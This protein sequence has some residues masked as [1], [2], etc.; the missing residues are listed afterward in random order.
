M[1]LLVTKA[2]NWH[3]AFLAISSIAIC[4]L[5]HDWHLRF[6]FNDRT[7][8]TVY[9]LGSEMVLTVQLAYCPELQCYLTIRHSTCV[10]FSIPIHWNRNLFP[11]IST[12]LGHLILYQ[13]HCLSHVLIVTLI[14]F[15]IKMNFRRPE[16]NRRTS[17]SSAGVGPGVLSINTRL[18]TLPQLQVQHCAKRNNS[19]SLRGGNTGITFRLCHYLMS[20][21]QSFETLP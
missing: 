11:V 5:N 3:H 8:Y 19:R 2:F 14:R 16:D 1:H 21:A 15:I 17:V 20:P 10:N 6:Q 18:L 7:R 13:F 4:A 12:A 9:L